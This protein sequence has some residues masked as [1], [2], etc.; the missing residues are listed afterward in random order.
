MLGLSVLVSVAD[1]FIL[2]IRVCEETAIDVIICQV[3][4]D[5]L[6]PCNRMCTVL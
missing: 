1:Q 5:I 3:R 6:N 2:G 4:Y